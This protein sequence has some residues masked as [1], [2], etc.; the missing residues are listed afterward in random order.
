MNN[1]DITDYDEYADEEFMAKR[2][3]NAMKRDEPARREEQ[4]RREEPKPKSE[5]GHPDSQGML[6]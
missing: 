5:P 2:G 4:I 3:G 6:V 1:I